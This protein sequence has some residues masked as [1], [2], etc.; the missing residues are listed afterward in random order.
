MTLIRSYNDIVYSPRVESCGILKASVDV[1]SDAGL[2][3][4]KILENKASSV[5]KLRHLGKTG[6]G[7]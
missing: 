2:H 4:T 5:R 6:W 3:L 7:A 1:L